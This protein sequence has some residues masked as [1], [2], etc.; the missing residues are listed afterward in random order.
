MH[1]VIGGGVSGPVVRSAGIK[2]DLRFMKS[3][4]YS[5]Y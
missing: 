1:D 4:T 5:N 2:R 3:E